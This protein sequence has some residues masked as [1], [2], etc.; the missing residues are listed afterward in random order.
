MADKV[1]RSHRR[2]F[3]RGR[4]LAGP[5][6]PCGG[7]PQGVPGICRV[8]GCTANNAC[9]HESGETCSW[10]QFD[11]CNFCDLIAR[12]EM[13]RSEVERPSDRLQYQ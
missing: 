5:Q 2:K 13:E 7:P 4:D 9:C 3:K 6:P 1:R 8:C 11:L 10:A 12:G